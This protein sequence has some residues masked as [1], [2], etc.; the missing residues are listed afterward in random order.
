MVRLQVSKILSPWK[1][2]HMPH[3]I[4]VSSRSQG[5]GLLLLKSGSEKTCCLIMMLHT[6]CLCDAGVAKPTAPTSCINI[7]H[8]LV[9]QGTTSLVVALNTRVTHIPIYCIILLITLSECI[10]SAYQEN[11][12]YKPVSESQNP[13]KSFLSL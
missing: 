13:F 7:Q 9:I 4:L 10:P 11:V 3:S 1:C 5:W 6:P 12:F 8:V 2:S